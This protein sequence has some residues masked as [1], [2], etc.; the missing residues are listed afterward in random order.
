MAPTT[1]CTERVLARGRTC[2]GP[3]ARPRSTRPLA[4]A[5]ASPLLTTIEAYLATGGALEPTARN[6]FVH[7]NTVRYRLHRV[8]EV[9]RPGPVAGP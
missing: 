2:R 3:A 4:A 6:L 1:C 9:D 5:A 7:P 8:A